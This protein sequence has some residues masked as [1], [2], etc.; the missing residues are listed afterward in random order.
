M[1]GINPVT[2][3]FVPSKSETADFR[4]YQLN[5]INSILLWV[6]DKNNTWQSELRD[7]QPPGT[8]IN[9]KIDLES[10][11]IINSFKQAEVYNPWTNIWI[12]VVPQGMKLS[13]PDFRRSLVIRIK[14]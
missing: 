10:L 2:E 9:V 1:K 8:N 12:S 7:L 5:G 6:R 13:L 3:K 11:G 14:K 4:I